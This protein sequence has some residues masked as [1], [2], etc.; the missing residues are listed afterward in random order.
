MPDNLNT[1]KAGSL[2]D[3]F[4][5]EQARA[6]ARKL[7]FHYTPKHG[8]WLNIAE[9]ELAVLSNLCL[10]QRI[11]DERTHRASGRSK[12]PRAQRKSRA[13]QLALHHPRR[14]AE[15]RSPL[16]SCFSLTDY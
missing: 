6:M 15:T 11:A 9:I 13:P 10:S 4:S 12:H 8:S 7:E 16:S 14:S 3:A 2:Y 5:P 1:H